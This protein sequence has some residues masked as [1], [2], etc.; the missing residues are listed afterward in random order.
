MNQLVCA[1]LILYG[2]QPA[3]VQNTLDHS[4]KDGLFSTMYGDIG[5]LE[6]PVAGLVETLTS[7]NLLPFTDKYL[8]QEGQNMDVFLRGPQDMRKPDKHWRGS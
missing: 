4:L 5:I 6:L 2:G 3:W 8:V 7:I 1:R